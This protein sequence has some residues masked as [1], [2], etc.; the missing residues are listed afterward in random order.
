MIRIGIV[1][2]DS[3]HAVDFTRIINAD[4]PAPARIVAACA[5]EPTDFPLSVSRRPNI[6]R[7]LREELGIPI[8]PSA[9]DLLEHVDAVMV[10]SC[11]GRCHRREISPLLSA[12]KPLFVDKPFCADWR[13]A[14]DVLRAARSAGTPCFSASA[15]RYRAGLDLAKTLLRER[16]AR[17]VCA[18]PRLHE[19]G[20]PDLSWYGIHG[21]EAAYALLGPGCQTVWRQ[22]GGD[23]DITTGAWPDGSEV[24][25]H[26]SN[27]AAGGEFRTTVISPGGE[28]TLRGHSYRDLLQVIVRFFETGQTPVA[29]NEMVEVLAFIA[30]ADASRDTHGAAIDL[31]RL[32]ANSPLVSSP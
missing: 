15:L 5:G 8:L 9:A 7:S 6:E 12:G 28:T 26:R 2:L 13:E 11:D 10:L 30:A 27:D 29:E 21:V 31:P 4:A 32:L 19:P 24:A 3:T 25:L 17:I 14:V 16:P 1:G 20:H 23:E 18:V 22:P